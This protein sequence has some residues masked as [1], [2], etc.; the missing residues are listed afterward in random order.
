MCDSGDFGGDIGGDVGGF[1]DVGSDIDTGFDDAGSDFD[2]SIDDIGSDDFS[3]ED[4][5]DDSFDIDTSFEADDF[6]SD[7]DDS[8]FA[9]DDVD[10]DYSAEDTSDNYSLDS[11]DIGDDFEIEDISD[12]TDLE[13]DDISDDEVES[14]ELDEELSEEYSEE[15]EELDADSDFEEE[16]EE[17]VEEEIETLELDD[18]V[19]D[20]NI[21]ELELDEDSVSESVEDIETLEMDDEFSDE[22]FAEALEEPSYDDLMESY[23]DG[24]IELESNDD[25]SEEGLEENSDEP[26][27]EALEESYSDG[28][29][30]EDFENAFSEEGLN[31]TFEEIE[32]VE[33]TESAIDDLDFDAIFED[34]ESN[35][36]LEEVDNGLDTETE[37]EMTEMEENVTYDIPHDDVSGNETT[38][39]EENIEYPIHEDEGAE[40]FNMDDIEQALLD[41]EVYDAPLTTEEYSDDSE[42]DGLSEQE[43]PPMT[44]EELG[45]FV[46]WENE[47][48]N[49]YYDMIEDIKN[50]PNLTDDQKEAMIQPLQE[51]LDSLQDTEPEYGA[52]VKGLTYDGRD[53]I[54]RPPEDIEDSNGDYR[55]EFNPESSPEF[56]DLT[57][58][59]E[60][61]GEFAP[62]QTGDYESWEQEMADMPTFDEYMEQMN[63]T[64]LEPLTDEEMDSVYEGLEEYDFHGVD[65]L[66]DTARLD[67]SLESFTNENWE[68]LSLGEQ[69]EKMED[70]AQYVIDV[71]GLENPPQIE[72]YNNPIEGDYGGFNRA[73]NTLS[74]NEH[75]LYQNDEAADT[76]AHELWHA[77][78]YQRASNP[79][80][81]IDQMYAE[82]FNDYITPNE[83]FEGYQ[84]QI[85]ESEARAFA[86]QIK[87]RLHSY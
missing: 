83:D 73:T 17:G 6:S 58:Q 47:H 2:T 7:F 28:F 82:N 36:I 23:D 14:L 9:I 39:M 5:S 50:D 42:I 16:L 24:Y 71:T 78:Q 26:S 4:V 25:V 40:E 18:E 85:L 8:D 67:D 59:P 60:T 74:I 22:E 72:F 57:N 87:D 53:I 15:A 38:E 35:D 29:I 51:E 32:T 76:V 63:E 55:G 37:N 62:N 43:I 66:E 19:T 77:L 21:E 86:Q 11:E 56:M 1:D 84:S 31:D 10:D 54:T 64:P 34:S 75:M 30:D 3:F 70:L 20:E 81:K 61:F 69:K 80:T 79:R 13:I 52:R 44:D 46:D 65:V 41:H 45:A 33:D 68:Q 48:N 12:D 27:Y 49:G